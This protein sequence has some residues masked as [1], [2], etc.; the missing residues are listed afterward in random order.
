MTDTETR[1]REQIAV[2]GKSLF[3]R[4][5]GVG[6][7]GNISVRLDDGILI[8]PTNTSMG[9]IDPARIA[10]V[11]PD[12][13]HVSG[14]KPSKEG[15]L[16]LA[17]YAK[18]PEMKAV[19]HLH[20]TYSVALST[21]AAQDPEAMLPPITAYYVMRVGN[22]PL[23]PYFPPGDRG[24]ADAVGVAMETAHAVLLANHGSVVAGKSLEEAVYGAEELEETAKLFFLLRGESTNFLSFAEVAELRARF[25]S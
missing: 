18:R 9:R 3:D 8:T 7:S 5:Y 19:V 11:A 4:G 17:V 15:F 12:G 24:L 10:K 21:L 2:M 6:S 22:L 20:S 14:D 25:P 23:V 13:S 16:H 1:F